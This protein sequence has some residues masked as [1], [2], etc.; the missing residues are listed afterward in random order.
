VIF[1][2]LSIDGGGMRG[3][4]SAAYLASLERAFC[5]RRRCHGLD[6]GKAFQLIVGTSTGAIIGCALAKG[7]SP[8]EIINLYRSHGTRIFPRKMPSS[9]G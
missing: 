2:V 7:K 9:L 5:E 8:N 6:I 4:Y 1:R 3:I